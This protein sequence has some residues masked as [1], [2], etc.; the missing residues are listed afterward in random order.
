MWICENWFGKN[1]DKKYVRNIPYEIHVDPVIRAIF[2]RLEII[3]DYK[4]TP[5]AG[6]NDRVWPDFLRKKNAKQEE[7]RHVM[8]S[9]PNS[10]F[11]FFCST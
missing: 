4:C 3:F 6:I 5:L 11:F 1:F 8:H 2:P 9:G 10:I 7:I